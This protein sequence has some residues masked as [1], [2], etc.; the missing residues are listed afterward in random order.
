[1]LSY[2]L[3]TSNNIFDVNLFSLDSYFVFEIGNILSC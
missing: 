3:Q 1:M 2:A